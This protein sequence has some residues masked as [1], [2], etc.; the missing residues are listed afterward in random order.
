MVDAEDLNDNNLS[1]YLSDV[2]GIIVPGDL[3]QGL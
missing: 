3:V 1:A 2:K